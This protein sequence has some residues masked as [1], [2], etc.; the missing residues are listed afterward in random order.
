MRCEQKSVCLSVASSGF[1]RTQLADLT[2][3]SATWFRSRKKFWHFRAI[4]T[5][6]IPIVIKQKAFDPKKRDR[7]LG[8]TTLIDA[9]NASGSKPLTPVLRCALY[10]RFAEHSFTQDSKA[11]SKSSA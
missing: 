6:D 1:L 10:V 3:L 11:G 7:R 4:R 2:N 8:G 5:F 9:N